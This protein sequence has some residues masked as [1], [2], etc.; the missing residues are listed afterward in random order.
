M[1]LVSVVLPTFNRSQTIKKAIVS[2]LRQSL[3]D[4]ELIVVDDASTDDTENLVAG[5][6][7][8]RIRYHRLRTNAG[9]GGARNAGID[10]ARADY[11]AFQDSDDVWRPEKLKVQL[12]VLQDTHA[13]Y[14][15]CAS[16]YLRHVDDRQYVVAPQSPKKLEQ[17]FLGQIAFNN[18]ISTQT[19]MA[20][21]K[22]LADIGAFDTELPQ[23]EDWDLCLRLAQKTQIAWL[24]DPLVDVYDSPDS[25]TRK[26][27]AGAIARQ[28][29]LGKY[30]DL[31]AR[32]PSARRRHQYTMAAIFSRCGEQQEARKALTGLLRSYPFHYKAI[33]RYMLSFVN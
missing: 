33:A 24:P 28:I 4:F 30:P 17:D 3:D 1:P 20:R 14:G 10:M 21:K 7:D 32:Y 6:S 13:R 15:A 25:L 23:L 31:F 11:I 27:R 19:L 5:I 16:A 12:T 2:V 9:A 22:N 26:V 29:I 8:P 18:F